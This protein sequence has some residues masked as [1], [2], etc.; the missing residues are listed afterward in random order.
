[1]IILPPFQA[2]KWFSLPTTFPNE[3]LHNFSLASHITQSTIDVERVLKLQTDHSSQLK[4]DFEKVEDVLNTS[5]S[6]T[7]H[8]VRTRELNGRL[9]EKLK[10]AEE[11]LARATTDCSRYMATEKNLQK[12]VSDLEA[13]LTT[14]RQQ[15]RKSPAD[16]LRAKE[17]H[18]R[19][20]QLQNQLEETSITLGEAR[21]M[22]KSKEN[23][24]CELQQSLSDTKI[25]LEDTMHRMKGV[26]NEN[27]GLQEQIR[28]VEHRVR[29]ELSRASLTS[30]DQNRAW[31]EQQIHK[32]KQEKAVADN[33]ATRF[34]E[35]LA[36]ALESLVSWLFFDLCS[37]VLTIK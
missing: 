34:Q 30:R 35:Q 32:L 28:T 25:S 10:T 8:L 12:T 21:E 14:A 16:S 29:E 36:I 9:E 2:G 26:E 19:V 13:D 7:E 3:C 15:L 22:L 37:I 24:I 5:A 17:E 33:S 20:I 11:A 18:E 6:T 23:E 31:F 4:S 1:M 27:A